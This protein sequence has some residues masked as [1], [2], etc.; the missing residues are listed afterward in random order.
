MTCPRFDSDGHFLRLHFGCRACFLCM[1]SVC[2]RLGWDSAVQAQTPGEQDRNFR[3]D[4]S[5]PGR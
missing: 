4:T 1:L 2:F 5:L 3:S